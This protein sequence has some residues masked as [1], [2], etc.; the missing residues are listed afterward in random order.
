LLFCL[1]A[2]QGADVQRKKRTAGDTEESVP[3]T[4]KPAIKE[5]DDDAKIKRTKP[6]EDEAN[7]KES[8]QAEDK[9]S[10]KPASATPFGG[11]SAASFV[12]FGSFSQT[13]S[14]FSA[15]TTA[16]SSTSTPS[17]SLFGPISLPPFIPP[18]EAPNSSTLGSL[19]LPP[20]PLF[21]GFS[22][23][24]P[25]PVVDKKTEIKGTA[26]ATGEEDEVHVF[27][28][29]AKLF[30]YD[31]ESSWKDRGL[32]ILHLNHDPKTGSSRLV[33]R[34]DA[35]FRVMLNVA[36]FDTM[37]CELSG[38]KDVRVSGFEDGKITT[39]WLRVQ[40][41]EIAN[42]LY[43]AVIKHRN[44][45]KKNSTEEKPSNGQPA[46]EAPLGPPLNPSA[47]PHT[48]TATESV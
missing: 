12:S 38:D 20:L 34:A 11:I 32:G 33:M 18:F 41:K 47:Q 48:A 37:I 6:Q 39:F 44:M 45:L 40:K 21:T 4:E 3:A 26:A 28:A 36:L 31:K 43:N 25:T 23:A 30:V 42:D 1:M 17:T 24:A 7:G 8:A 13:S 29:K 16:P 19:N 2:D 5:S 35:V 10:D 46:K 9:S 15:P 14:A 27:E 22:S